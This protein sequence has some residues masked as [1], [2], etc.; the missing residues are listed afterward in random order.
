MNRWNPTGENSPMTVLA[1]DIA[2]GG[3]DKTTRA[4]RHGNWFARIKSTPGKDTPDGP[5]VSA[6]IISER[7]DGC[8]IV[9]D[10]GG[11]YG[12]STN[13]HLK[14]NGIIPTLFNGGA[15]AEGRR[16]RSGI[17][18]FRNI[19]AAAHWHLWEGLDPANGSTIALPPDPELKAEMVSIRYRPTPGGILIEEKAEVKARI[20]RSPDRSDAV[21]MC[22]FARGMTNRSGSANG[23]LQTQAIVS[24]RN[25]RR[26]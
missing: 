20:G 19:R 25:P 3:A 13:D 14:S 18:K 22:N 6:I 16:D 24:G 4:A 17:L 8:E 21:V 11:G 26:R 10:M 7:R 5:T 12:G 9:I 1:A 23:P 15:G 2:Q